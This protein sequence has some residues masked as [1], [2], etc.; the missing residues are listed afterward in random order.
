MR[1]ALA[2]MHLPSW[3]LTSKSYDGFLQL[4]YSDGKAIPSRNANCCAEIQD[5]PVWRFKSPHHWCRE[6]V[7]RTFEP[8]PLLNQSHTGSINWLVSCRFRSSYTRGRTLIRT[9]ES[10]H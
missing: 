5:V 8:K 9:S 2:V 6:F 3:L 10:G 7:T 4:A 1:T